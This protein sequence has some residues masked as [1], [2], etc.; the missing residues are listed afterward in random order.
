MNLSK[1]QNVFVGCLNICP[2]GIWQLGA[3]WVDNITGTSLRDT[4]TYKS[5]SPHHCSN[6]QMVKKVSP[7]GRRLLNYF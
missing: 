1:F 4:C 2:R 6:I 3:A 5:L 7:T